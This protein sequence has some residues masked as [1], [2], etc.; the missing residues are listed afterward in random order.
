MD[1]KGKMKVITMDDVTDKIIDFADLESQLEGK[2]GEKIS[3]IRKIKEEKIGMKE[4]EL[5][6]REVGDA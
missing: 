2:L 1:D 4:K 5:L 6:G 3:E